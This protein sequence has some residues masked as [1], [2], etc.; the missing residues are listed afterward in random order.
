[1][2]INWRWTVT[3]AGRGGSHNPFRSNRARFIESI[4]I[5]VKKV[6]RIKA[7]KGKERA[8]K[9]LSGWKDVPGWDSRCQNVYVWY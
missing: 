8:G 6:E 3:A 9:G 2:N 1:M 7:V 4:Y 5:H